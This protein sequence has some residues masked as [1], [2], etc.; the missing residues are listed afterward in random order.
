[1]LITKHLLERRLSYLK[2]FWFAWNAGCVLIIAG[3]ASLVH[4][5]FPD[6]LVSY[7][8]RKCQA[9]ARLSRIRKLHHEKQNF[10]SS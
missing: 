7:S 10:F 4:A 6:L 2:H 9:L 8:E 5:F 3:V 1:M